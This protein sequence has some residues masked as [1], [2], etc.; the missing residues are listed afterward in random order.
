MAS[1]SILLLGGTV[2]QHDQS[3]QIQVL[4]KTDILIRG[5]KIAKIGRG[6]QSQLSGEDVE[7][8][9]CTDQIVTPGFIDTHH[10][11]WQT[12]LRGRYSDDTLL[13]YLTP[14][15]MQS[16]NF[17]PEDIFWGQLSGGLECIDAGTT[18][19]VDHMHASYS[20]DHATRALEASETSGLRSIYAYAIPF[21]LRRWTKTVA[22]VEEDLLPEW[23]LNQIEDLAKAGPRADGR[24]HIGLAFDFYFLPQEVLKSVFHRARTAGVKLITSHAA[25]NAVLGSQSVAKILKESGLIGPDIIISHGNNYSDEDYE[26]FTHAGVHISSTPD[27]E[28]QMGMGWP[29]ALRPDVQGTIGVDSSALTSTSLLH[30]ARALLQMARQQTNQALLDR[31]RF[32]KT[33]RSSTNEVF[34]MMTIS[35]ARAV[36][37]ADQIG[38]IAEGKLAD[39][40][41]FD[42]RSSNMVPAAKWDPVAAVVRHSDVR[43]LR[44]VIVDGIVRKKDGKLLPVR[45]GDGPSLSWEDVAA[46]VNT[47]YDSIEERAAQTSIPV[48]RKALVD[49]WHIDESKLETVV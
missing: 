1:K 19:I 46:K 34:N 31:G 5:Q 6:L 33:L 7:I 2:L 27:T 16:Y 38:S 21:R 25:N 13:D 43:D 35:G 12:Q 28:C 45:L 8:L 26:I 47:S 24:I 11:C 32:P 18:F 17:S 14:G 39:L 48:G 22:E 44:T 4:Q 36:G 3:G 37:L 15:M 20:P 30:Q 41:V 23:A 9:D 29:V 10:H 40:L 49:A 42:T